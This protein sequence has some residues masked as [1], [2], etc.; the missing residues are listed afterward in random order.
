MVIYNLHNHTGLAMDYGCINLCNASKQE[1]IAKHTR[2]E[3]QLPSS[4]LF[5]P[6]PL[7]VVQL[8]RSVHAEK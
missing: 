7:Y 4:L 6:L 1:A 5:L 3:H 8:Q 2:I